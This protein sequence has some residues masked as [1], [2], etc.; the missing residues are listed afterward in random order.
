MYISVFCTSGLIRLS[1]KKK[2]PASYLK[3]VDHSLMKGCFCNCVILWNVWSK[4]AEGLAGVSFSVILAK[5]I[6]DLH[7]ERW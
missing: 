3:L 7:G 1:Y 5:M 2:S 6:R 4:V